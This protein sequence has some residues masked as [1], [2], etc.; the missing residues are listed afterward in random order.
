[1]RQ[2][3][4]RWEGYGLGGACGVASVDCCH[5]VVYLLTLTESLLPQLS[6]QVLAVIACESACAGQLPV[7]QADACER[8]IGAS[9]SDPC[10]TALRDELLR[11]LT[12]GISSL[13]A[14]EGLMPV[15][16]AQ[17]AGRGLPGSATLVCLL[18]APTAGFLPPPFC[19]CSILCG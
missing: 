17:D 14:F 11:M 1:M 6:A 4:H 12:T 10:G 7:R 9:D 16:L 19:G 2:A 13:P 18:H 8:Q 3:D 15:R 5:H